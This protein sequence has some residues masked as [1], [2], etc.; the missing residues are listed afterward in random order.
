MK[1]QLSQLESQAE[2]RYMY[3]IVNINRGEQYYGNGR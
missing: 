3:D 1:K 2:N